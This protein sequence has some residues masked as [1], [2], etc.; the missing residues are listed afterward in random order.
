MKRGVLISLILLCCA[1]LRAQWVAGRLTLLA[2]QPLRLEGFNGLKTY[3]IAA[4]TIDEQGGFKLAYTASD[5]GVGYLISSDNQPLFVILSGEEVVLQGETLG[6]RASL[7]ILQGPQNISFEQ[8]AATYPRRAQALTA[9]TFLEKLY[10]S[11]S[12]FAVQTV[13]AK[14]IQVEKE[15]ISREDDSCLAALPAGS[16]VQW[17]LPVRKLVS[18]VPTVLQYRPEEIPATIAAFRQLDYADPRL[19]K[20]GLFK[21]AIEQHFLLLENSGLPLDSVYHEMKVSIDAMVASLTK[22]E[23]K[24]NE[25]TDFLFDLLEKRS[26]FSASEYLALKVLNEVNCTL[27]NNLARQLEIYRAMKKGNIAPDFDF[28]GEVLAAGFTQGVLPGK[29]SAIHSEYTAVIFG[30]SW[31]PKCKTEMAE[32]AGLYPKWKNNKVEIVFV[33]LD[34]DKAAYQSFAGNFPFLSVCDYR[35]WE[36][37]VVKSYYVFGTPTIFLLNKKREIVLRPNSVKQLDAWVDW[38]L[39]QGN[40]GPR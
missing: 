17:F 10:A 37:E 5:Y 38:F 26:L 32:V 34:D 4:T 9:W 2:N 40:P 3:P 31:C 35:K 7:R 39:V 18:A 16:Y 8:Y 20:S 11:D 14:A 19:Y 33:S 15:R 21:D 36:G 1:P 12:L 25:A 28:K 6:S 30:A 23:R 24:L 29:L 22:D 27:D 13:P